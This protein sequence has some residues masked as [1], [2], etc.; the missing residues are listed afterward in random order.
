VKDLFDLE[1]LWAK[2]WCMS[3][4]YIHG[5]P[6]MYAIVFDNTPEGE[7]RMEEIMTLCFGNG[8]RSVNTNKFSVHC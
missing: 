8:C 5:Y 1:N 2:V 3:P 6:E 7:S 4:V